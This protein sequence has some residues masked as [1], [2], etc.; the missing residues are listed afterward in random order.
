[1][2]VKEAL[3]EAILATLTRLMNS[4]E[5]KPSPIPDFVLETPKFEEHGDLA[6]NAAL[7]LASSQKTSPRA[8]AEAILRGFDDS[9]ALVSHAETAG[10]GF[11]NFFINEDRWRDIIS[12]IWRQQDRFGQSDLGKG[13]RVQV[14]FVSANP[15][16]PLHVG[17]GRGASVG[18]VLANL[19]Q[20]SGHR[21]HREY[22]INDAGTQMQTLGRSVCLR[23]QEQ[24]GKTVDYPETCYQGEY[25]RDIAK[26]LAAQDLLSKVSSENECVDL[27]SEYAAT[28]ILDGIRR[29]LD[30][31]GVRFDRWMSEKELTSQGTLDSVFLELERKGLTYRED[32]ALWFRATDFGDEKDRVLVRR[33]GEAT[34]FA[35]DVAYH[36]DKLRRGFETIIDVWG[37]DHHGYVPRIRAI[38]EASGPGGKDRFHAV[39][40]QLVNLVRAGQPVSM[41]TRA[42]TFVTLREVLDE[43][44]SDAARF[45][46]LTRRADSALDF[47]LDVAKSQTEDNP[48]F[49]VQYAHAR[50]CS[51]LRIAEERNI[52]MRPPADVRLDLLRE[53]EEIQLLKQLNA[54]P[55]IVAL[56]AAHLEAHRLPYYLTELVGGFHRFYRRHRIMGED[57]E[58]TQAR[59]CF[60]RVI[61]TVIRN[62]LLLLGITAPESM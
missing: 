5:L 15:T 27:C 32:G 40:V 3:K 36:W 42:G 38:M 45:M 21:V 61:R 12:V 60:V 19:L 16:G 24:A 44:G 39:L 35:S 9:Q 43:V 7:L 51:V 49:Y 52:P 14:E 31:F 47:D 11:I 54:F 4:G 33:T 28:R 8:I 23:Y 10:P 57:P 62:G 34:Y 29:D 50:I 6:T 46:F 26:E 20:A 55:E 25:I 2:I 17:H 18:D 41:S 58:L 59:L 30:S 48:V 37:A 22:Y 13:K 56:S 53:K 1:M